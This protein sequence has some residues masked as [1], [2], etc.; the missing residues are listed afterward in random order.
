M[1]KPAKDGGREYDPVPLNRSVFRGILDHG[2]M[3]SR[4][5]VVFGIRG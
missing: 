2:E 3:R 1:M 5:V 4:G